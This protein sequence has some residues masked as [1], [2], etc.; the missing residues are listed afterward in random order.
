MTDN[1]TERLTDDEL[2]D[3]CGF[4][5]TARQRQWL[6]QNG[7]KYTLNAAQRPIVG[8]WYARMKLAGI[9]PQTGDEEGWVP[10]FTNVS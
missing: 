3:M 2:A 7:W 6:D 10:D 5:Q 9:N 1:N 8:R 4:R